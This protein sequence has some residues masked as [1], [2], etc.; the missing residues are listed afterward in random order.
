MKELLQA[1][2][3][4]SELEAALARSKSVPGLPLK[5]DGRVDFTKDFFG[6]P[7]FLTVSGQLNGE[8]YASAL[9]DIYTFGPTFRAE[10]SNTNRHLAEFWMVEPEL[11]FADLQADMDCAEA[12]VKVRLLS[13]YPYPS[14]RNERSAV[15]FRSTASNASSTSAPTSL[16][17][18]RQGFGWRR[19]RH[20]HSFD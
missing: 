7:S 2:S 12:Y 17:F 11:C 9:G 19:R 14:P 10:N 18:L 6:K 4:L 16:I 15:P 5:K 1:K 20:S 8:I 3:E 13:F